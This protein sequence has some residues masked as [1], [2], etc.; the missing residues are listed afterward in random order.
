MAVAQGLAAVVLVVGAASGCASG[1]GSRATGPTATTAVTTASVTTPPPAAPVTA[2]TSTTQLRVTTTTDAGLLPQTTAEPDSGAGLNASFGVLW[3]AIVAGTPDAALGVFFPRTAYVRMKTGVIPDP[4]GDYANRLLAFYRLDLQAYHAY[5]G[6]GAAAAR[7]IG[8]DADGAYASWI[9]PGGCENLIGYWHLPGVRLV[10]S[11][12][13]VI[14]SFAV[15]SLI[16]W[17]SVWYVVH[18]GP[19]PRPSDVG[20]VDQAAS[21]PGIPGP[22]GGC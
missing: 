15:A 4:A 16:S 19:N 18:L 12:G 8:V 9:A 7:L 17:H 22:P 5:L 14:D 2:T 21:G 11:E 6:P 10:Y 3:H 20:T 13:G 1:S